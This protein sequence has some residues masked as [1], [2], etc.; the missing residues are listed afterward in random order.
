MFHL[1]YREAMGEYA[2]RAGGGRAAV[3]P[4]GT[5]ALPRYF[6]H[7]FSNSHT[8]LKPISSQNSLKLNNSSS[9]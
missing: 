1:P 4:G 3:R 9:G 8:S 5:H 2:R 6:A 7:R